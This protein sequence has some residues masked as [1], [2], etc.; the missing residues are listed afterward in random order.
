MTTT[1]AAVAAAVTAVTAIQSTYVC[2][3]TFLQVEMSARAII[4]L[5][6]MT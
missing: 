1:A 3:R 4:C 2:T 5:P 6:Y